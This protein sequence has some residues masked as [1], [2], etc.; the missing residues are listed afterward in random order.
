MMSFKHHILFILFSYPKLDELGLK[1]YAVP[2]VSNIMLDCGGLQFTACPFNGW[3]MATEVGAR[4]FTD[5]NR[6]NLLKVSK[7]STP[8]NVKTLPV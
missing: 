7:D 5:T 8:V 6:Y 2:A 3:Y 4:N 1:W